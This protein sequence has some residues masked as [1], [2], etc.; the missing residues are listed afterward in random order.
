MKSLT[1][2]SET[3]VPE[4]IPFGNH[5]KRTFHT[6]NPDN[7]DFYFVRFLN[8]SFS[9]IELVKCSETETLYPKISV[10]AV[11]SNGDPIQELEEVICGIKFLVDTQSICVAFIN[12]DIVTVHLDGRDN[13]DEKDELIELV[14]SIDSLIKCM[15]WSPDEE[16]VIFVT[17]NDTILEMTKDFDVITEFPINVEDLGEAVSISVGWGKKET[18]FHGSEGKLAA[19]RVVDITNFTLSNDDDFKPRIS[20]HDDGNMFCCSAI[21]TNRGLRVIRVY[22]REGVLQSTS[23]PVDKLS[24]T[25][26]WRPSGNLIASNQKFPDKHEI[27]FFEKNGLRHGEFSLRETG[28]HKVVEILWNCD[29][30]ILAIWLERG[31]SQSENSSCVQ[32][33][34]MNNYHWYLKQEILIKADDSVISVSWD[35]ETA[36]RLYIVTQKKFHKFEFAWDNLCSNYIHEKDAAAIAVIDGSSV[37]LTPFRFLNVPPPMCAFTVKLESPASYV[38]FSPNNGGNDFAVLQINQMI[39]FFD[40]QGALNKPCTPPTLI[41]SIKLK[42]LDSKDHGF[43]R[44]IAWINKEILL[45][46]LNDP[47]SRSDDIFLVKMDFKEEF[48]PIVRYVEKICNSFVIKRLNWNPTHEKIYLISNDGMVFDV[49]I[50]LDQFNEKDEKNNYIKVSDSPF[51]CFPESCT[52]VESTKIGTEERIETVIIGLSENNKLYANEKLVTTGCTSFFIHNNFLILTTL[53]HVARFLSLRVDLSDLKVSENETLPYDE[54]VRRIERGSKI[55]CAVYY[56]VSLILQMPRGNLETISPRALVLASVRDALNRLDYKTAYIDCRK[57]RIDLNILYDHSPE[58][59]LKNVRSFVLQVEKVDYLNLFLSNLRNEDVILTMYP[60]VGNSNKTDSTQDISTK[61]NTI[62]DAIREVLETLDSKAYL[63][64]II[65]TY[66]R[67]NPPDLESSLGLLAKLKD[68]DP[69]LAEDAIKFAI[70]LVDA[71]QLFDVALGMYDFRLVLLVAQQSQ[72]DPREY[73]PFLADLENYPMHYQRFKIDDHLHRYE[74]A[75]KNLSLAGDENFEECLKYI[76]KHNLYKPAISLF[77][78]SK[79]KYKRIMFIYGDYLFKESN[80]AEAGLAYILAEVKH[81]AIVAYKNA[82]SW[83]EALAIAQEMKYSLDDIFDLTLNLAEI[84]EDKRQYQEAAQIL[85]DYVKET[86]KS[87]E[88]LCK[89][90]HWV[91]A[92]RVSYMYNREDLIQSNIRPSIIE[93][94]VQLLQD[95]NSMLDQL[96]Q[97]TTRLKEIRTNKANQPELLNYDKSIDNIDMFSDT[98]SMVSGFSHYTQSN[99][100]LSIHS[101]RSSKSAKSRRRTERKKAR[102]KKGSIYE[103]VYLLDSLKRL[104]ERFNSTQVEISNLLKCLITLGIMKSAQQIQTLFSKLEES[105]KMNIDEIFDVPLTTATETTITEDDL[106]I[107]KQPTLKVIEKPKISE[108]NWKLQIII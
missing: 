79:E 51:I 21:D 12:G 31:D 35:P 80:Y 68:K 58:T 22:N 17:G 77:S 2:L 73:L 8:P 40:W 47:E 19:Q 95:V 70:F 75:L 29:S 60:P 54:A 20:W 81:K 86:E 108:L 27:I 87:I 9:N 45:C 89:G 94:H 83:R 46:I 37:Y 48:N 101:S 24:Y 28:S 6:I 61:V 16:L 13:D 38:S 25:L 92:M 98:S 18:Q 71:D 78:N 49:E 88:L 23:E 7:G 52:W 43:I 41:G 50:N 74:K 34:N 32:L 39:T 103:E 99:T 107:D 66:V 96:N 14:G 69:D 53:S 84:L 59:F 30:T 56:D 100:Q 85:L 104:I 64:S 10:V 33:W 11:F 72:K 44:Q 105:I 42:L 36:L 62:C 63:K 102:G 26:S 5:L 90:H 65:T 55:V 93:G 106:T 91:E 67:R 76:V 97:Q 15:E 57:H 82:G 4:C 1:L 3:I